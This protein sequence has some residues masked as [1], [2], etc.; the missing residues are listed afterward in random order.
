MESARRL[1]EGWALGSGGCVARTEPSGHCA[2]ALIDRYLDRHGANDLDA[3]V[4]LFADDATLE[5]PVGAPVLLGQAAIRAFFRATHAR[6]GRL[7][8]ERVG[9]LLV[10]GDELALH[11]R[12]RLA[13]DPDSPGMDVIYTLRFEP[14]GGRILALRAYF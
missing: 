2:E 11:V 10:Q 9:P 14:E 1:P 12:A 4:A 5:D 6:N 3:V 7:V 13:S 8:F